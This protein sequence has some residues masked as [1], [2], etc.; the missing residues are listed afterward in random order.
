MVIYT[1]NGFAEA[2]SKRYDVDLWIIF[3]NAYEIS[4]YF[5][6]L[7]GNTI[8]WNDSSEMI[9]SNIKDKNEF[10]LHITMCLL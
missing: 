3:D 4:D 7:F 2:L 5:E 6:E 1:R 8:S 10:L 9:V